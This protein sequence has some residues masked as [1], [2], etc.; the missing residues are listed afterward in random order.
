MKILRISDGSRR[1]SAFAPS[2]PATA[3]G[4]RSGRR[5]A[6]RLRLVPSVSWKK[7]AS[8]SAR[9]AAQLVDRQAG[10]EGDVAHESQVVGVDQQATVGL[11]LARDVGDA[12]GAGQLVGVG[13]ADEHRASP[14]RSFIGPC[15]IRR[16]LAM[17]TT[18]STVCSTS[19]SMWLETRMVLPSEL[20]WRRKPAQ[21]PDALGVEAVGRLVEDED[22]GGRRASRRR[23]RAADACPWSSRRPASSRQ[24]GS[25]PARASRRRAG[26]RD[27]GR[28]GEHPQVVAPG[29]PGV[30]V[31]RLEGRA[32]DGDRLGISW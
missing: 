14:C 25:R 23:G 13:G 21:P 24:P 7:S 11:G 15:L 6:P 30:E 12:Q 4:R 22:A 2:W 28:V 20:R 31:R 29:A 19:W 1:P 17:M 16:P 32:H 18:S 27:A 26:R 3:S 10:A 8:R 9:G 5:A